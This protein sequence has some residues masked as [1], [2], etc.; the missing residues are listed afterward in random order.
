M[1]ELEDQ[2]LRQRQGSDSELNK[3]LFWKERQAMFPTLKPVA[4]DLLA[5]AASQAYVERIFQFVGL[6]AQAT[7][8]VCQ[9]LSKQEFV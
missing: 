1:A 3:L 5:A 4:E 9:S 6:R 2:S 7:E 8:I